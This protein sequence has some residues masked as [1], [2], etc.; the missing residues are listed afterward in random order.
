ML[1][2]S[3]QEDMGVSHFLIVPT[4][5]KNMTAVAEDKAELKK[6]QELIAGKKKVKRVHT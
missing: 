1:C 4:D 5:V 3:A 2:F 6:S